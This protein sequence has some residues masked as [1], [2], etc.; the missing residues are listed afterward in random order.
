MKRKF[1]LYDLVHIKA[2]LPK[3]MSHFENDIDAIVVKYDRNT[4]QI[5]E[6][7]EHSYSLYIKG[8]GEASWYF[9]SNLE[10]VKRG[11]EELLK[12]WKTTAKK[13]R[14]MRSDLDWIFSNGQDVI[15]SPESASIEALAEPL[16]VNNMWGTN[17]EGFAYYANAMVIISIAEPFLKNGDKA[18]W[19]AFC[20]E[21]GTV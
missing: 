6:D 3:M 17:G 11:Q 5:G 9:G 2:E 15:Q 1:K 20:K 18:G 21:K 4:S 7:I 14:K 8:C 13:M 12:K 19:L 16:G 10:L